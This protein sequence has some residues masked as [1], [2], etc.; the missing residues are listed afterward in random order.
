MAKNVIGTLIYKITGDTSKLDKTLKNT[1]DEVKKTGKGFSK[2]GTLLKGAAVT[3]A[4]VGLGKALINVGKNAVNSFR[5]QETAEAKLE[6]T[7]KSTG[8][9]AGLTA[10]QLKKMASGLQDVTTFGDEAIIGSESLL[11]TFKDIGEDVFPRALESILDVSSAMGQDLQTTTIQLGKALNDP[12]SGLASLSR[13]GIQFTE[14]QKKLIKSLTESGDKAGAQSIIL[15]ELESQFGGVSK[16]VATTAEGIDKQLNNS[17]GDLLE[18]VG[19]VI[20][21]AMIPYKKALK[22][23]IESV[24]DSVKANILRKKILQEIATTG[25]TSASDTDALTKAIDNQQTQLNKLNSEYETTLGYVKISGEE[26]TKEF[27]KEQAEKKKTLEDN[28]RALRLQLKALAENK[29]AQEVYGDQ[30]EESSKRE[31]EATKKKEIAATASKLLTDRILE[32]MPEEEKEIDN[33]QKQID[34]WVQ[35]RDVPGVQA[36]INDLVAERNKLL[37][38]SNDETEKGTNLDSEKY[39]AALESEK[40][41]RQA[42]IDREK[43]RAEFAANEKQDIDD[44]KK[45]LRDYYDIFLDGA[46][47]AYTATSGIL[48]SLI[49]LNNAL[50]QNELDSL[51]SQMEAELEA[52]GV[53]EQTRLEELQDKKDKGDEALTDEEEKE[54][55]RLKIQ[56]KYNKKKA[57]EEYEAALTTWELQEAL[58]IASGALSVLNALATQPFWLGLVMAAV[59]GVTTGIEIAALEAAKPTPPSFA[60]GGI[61]PGTSFT[62][63]NVDAKV[64]SGEMILTQQM[65]KELLNIVSGG[66]SGGDQTIVVKIGESELYKIVNRGSKTGRL[67]IDGRAVV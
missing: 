39:N 43:R 35:F 1:N 2:L 65:Q 33:L 61:V 12:I 4:V 38:E 7:I 29:A 26:Q 51:D 34:Y 50:L 42:L 47:K 62:G 54:L 49:D 17:Y 15:G 14:D 32:R 19:S 5:I 25:E 6:Q 24:N 37:K 59:A 46:N 44:A 64:N 53:S 23:E 10:D 55:E 11:L 28:I 21:N 18:T 66:G 20:D 31:E 60:N 27:V 3:G 16:A 45:S 52:A 63:D 67:T 58:A 22:E 36:L 9:A 13:V 48:N 41:Y 8:S 30:I 40:Q 57:K 56:K